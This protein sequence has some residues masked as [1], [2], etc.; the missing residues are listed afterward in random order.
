MMQP[1]P[2]EDVARRSKEDVLAQTHC[3]YFRLIRRNTDTERRTSE[4]TVAT[5]GSRG[6]C[7]EFLALVENDPHYSYEYVAFTHDV[8][9]IKGSWTVEINDEGDGLHAA[10][11][12]PWSNADSSNYRH[13]ENRIRGGGRTKAEA[14]ASARRYREEL[15]VWERDE[16]PK[17]P[18]GCYCQ[19]RSNKCFT[20]EREITEHMKK[21]CGCPHCKGDHRISI[22]ADTGRN[23]AGLV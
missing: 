13:G 16:L 8:S 6:P 3:G 20:C 9:S 11:W 7:E 10:S 19:P 21:V 18:K 2:F 22:R 14:I 1:S 23:G 12:N 5:F 17:R 4:E 15:R